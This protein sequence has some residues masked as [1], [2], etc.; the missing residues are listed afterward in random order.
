MAGRACTAG[1]ER[2]GAARH[3]HWERRVLRGGGFGVHGEVLGARELCCSNHRFWVSQ[4]LRER[5]RGQ[6]QGA[7]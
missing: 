2:H 3:H 5:V 4:G 1:G 7:W 6:E